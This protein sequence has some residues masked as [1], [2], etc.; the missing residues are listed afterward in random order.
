LLLPASPCL[1]HYW[2]KKVAPETERPS[3]SCCA[4]YL[5][6][7][8]LA[9][10]QHYWAKKMGLKPEDICLVRPMLCSIIFSCLV[11]IGGPEDIC[12]VRLMLCSNGCVVIR[13]CRHGTACLMCICGPEDVCLVRLQWSGR[14]CLFPG[15]ACGWRRL[16]APGAAWRAAVAPASQLLLEI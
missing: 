16:E 13:A 6:P 8:L 9:C 12:L 5:H 7:H 1:Q 15:N 2:A 11:C 10:L 3:H 4:I 14:R